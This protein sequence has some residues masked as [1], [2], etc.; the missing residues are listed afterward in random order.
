MTGGA[1]VIAGTLNPEPGI[2][3]FLVPH[4]SFFVLLFR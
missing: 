3:F 4:P 2:L 1:V